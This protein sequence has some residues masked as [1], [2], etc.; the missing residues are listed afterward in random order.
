MDGEAHRH[1]KALFMSL[2]T[3]EHEQQLADLFWKELRL[4]IDKWESAGEIVLFDEMNELLCKV[5]C[6]WAGV[7]LDSS[8]LKETAEDFYAMVDAFGAVGPR[9]W[10][11]DALERE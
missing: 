11:V 1:R 6:S 3:V 8:Q 5:A 2:M 10:K 7:P 4:S 9:H